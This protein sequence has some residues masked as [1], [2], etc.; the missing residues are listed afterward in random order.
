[1][2]RI[3]FLGTPALAVTTLKGL[4]DAGHDL[5]IV[6]TRP[7]AKRGRGGALSPSPVKQWALDHGLVVS[8]DLG[9]LDGLDID[10]GVVVA[11][12]AL[13]PGS[14]VDAIPML[15]IHFSELPRWRGAAPVERAILAGDE[16]I[17][18][19]VMH[20]V[21]ELDAGAVYAR[22]SVSSGEKSL[23]QLWNELS[24]LGTE[25]LCELLKSGDLNQ[26]ETHEQVG[27]ISYAKKVTAEDLHLDFETSSE[28]LLRQIRLGKA[29]T[30]AGGERVVIHEAR[31]GDVHDLAPGHLA[32][33]TVG[34]RDGSLVLLEVQP[35]GKRAMDARDWRRGSGASIDRFDPITPM[36]F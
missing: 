27:E 2:A 13:L 23:Q 34:T 16:D 11:Y 25:L 6:I 31:R 29:W 14:L 9:D 4:V 35:A 33:T 15:N 30:R 7:D 12:G 8:H 21:E 32:G 36:G 20:I 10:L 3:A 26:M 17:G 28:Q 24:E 5:A 18:V 22:A 19:C 1:M